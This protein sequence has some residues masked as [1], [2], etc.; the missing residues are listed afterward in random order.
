MTNLSSHSKALAGNGIALIAVVVATIAAVTDL[1]GIAAGAA[2]MS[3]LALIAAVYFIHRAQK[4]TGGAALVCRAISNGDFE[5]R[6]VRIGDGGE[7][8]QLQHGLNNMIDRCDAFVREATA[9]MAALRDDKYYRRILPQGLHGALRIAATAMNDTTEVIQARVSAFNADTAQ[10]EAAIGAI[11]GASGAASSNIGETSKRLNQGATTTRESAT[12]VSTRSEEATE[13]MQTVAS[14]ATELSASAQEV[15][16]D[17]DR[18]TQI[19]QQ[20]VTRVVEAS[21]IVGGLSSA[22]ERIGSV[23]ALITAVAE[24]TDLLALN[25]TIEAARAG[26]AGR[27]FAVV[28]QEVKSLA[29]QTAKA[30]SEISAHIDGVQSMTKTAVDSI[31]QIGTIITEMSEITSHLAGA[32]HHQT[33]ATTEIA[34]HVDRAFA[35]VSE[36]S[37]RVRDVTVTA[38]ETEVLAGTT[39]VASGTLSQQAQDLATEVDRFLAMLRRPNT[40]RTAA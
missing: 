12:T 29:S 32:V 17:V 31:T 24:Q 5:A 2:G 35:G 19:A 14:A 7:L 8:R 22:A 39:M 16:R 27:G 28:A 6:V 40:G 13:N 3:G 23:V 33:A 37:G 4:I 25:A 36:I 11:V 26:E 15:G 20:A 34:N 38:G 10:F 18:S 30:T 9:A 21:Q 1:P